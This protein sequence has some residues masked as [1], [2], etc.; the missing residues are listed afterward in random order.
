MY[1][2]EKKPAGLRM[3]LQNGRTTAAGLHTEGGHMEEITVLEMN[4][5]ELVQFLNFIREDVIVNVDIE[6]ERGD[7][8]GREAV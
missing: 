4:M 5:E 7:E 1:L 8:N 6:E 2:T 3:P